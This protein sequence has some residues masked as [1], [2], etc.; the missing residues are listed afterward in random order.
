MSAFL[1]EAQFQSQMG[2]QWILC[3]GRNVAGSDYAVLTGN[4]VVPDARGLV[5]R[6]KNNGRADGNQNPDGEL[7]VGA[8]QADAFASHGHSLTGLNS[9]TGAA[10]FPPGGAGA[11]LVMPTAVNANGGNETRMKNLTGNHFIKINY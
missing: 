6:G 2:T 7:A 5:I 1:T 9:G 8:F 11:T 3:D 10:A 4:T